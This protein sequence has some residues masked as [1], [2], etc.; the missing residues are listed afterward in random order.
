[1]L[2]SARYNFRMTEF[3]PVTLVRQTQ[4]Q[5][6]ID[7]VASETRRLWREAKLSERLRPG[8]RVAVGVGSRGI[9]NLAT[10]VRATVDAVRE[11]GAEPFIVAAM[12]SHGGATPEGQRELLAGYDVTEATMGIP[13]V[14]AMETVQLGV[15]AHGVPVWW[16]A[17]AASADAVVLVSRIKPHT[18]FRAPFESGVAKMLAIGL[19]KQRGA[20]EHH[21]HGING[22]YMIP[23]SARIVVANTKFLAALAV[24]ENAREQ[25]AKLAIV[26]R[27]DLFDVEPKLLDEARELMGRLPFEQIDLLVIGEIGKNYSGSGIDPNVV[28]RLYAEC[29]PEF[30]SPKITRICALDLSPESHGN[31]TG[32]GLA[33]LTTDRLLAAFDPVPTRMNILTACFLGRTKLPFGFP[34]DRDCLET[35][36]ATCWQPDAAK[37]RMAIIPNT[38]EVADLWVTGPLAAEAATR[39]H[40]AVSG[41]PRALP[42]DAASNL[43]QE[44]LFPHSVRGRR[45]R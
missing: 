11:S 45:A 14:T 16:D 33:D 29:Q 9:A 34:T 36:Y 38:L 15:N 35:G 19:G 22:L 12:G 3:P 6:V 30:T 17:N 27:D 44:Q 1:M 2:Q 23:D 40:L 5:P 26:G 43:R 42:F 39:P 7:D 24:V 25:T 13:V 4:P 18:D 28:G 21:K 8:M 41:D 20:A 31:A 37:V 32:I 10:L